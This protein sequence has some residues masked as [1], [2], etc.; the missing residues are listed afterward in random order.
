MTESLLLGSWQVR[1]ETDR[2]WLS[3]RTV[4][5]ALWA[6]ATQQ[7]GW[8]VA[9]AAAELACNAV[10]YAGG[11]DVELWLEQVPHIA[12]GLV[13]R[14]SGRGFQR[15][16]LEALGAAQGVSGEAE[17]TLL[18]FRSERHGLGIGL[19]AVHRLMSEV[20]IDSSP[21]GTTVRARKALGRT[22]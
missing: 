22:R 18:R 14:D 4:E 1:A 6:G 3:R 9:I 21:L 11:G 8:E 2:V 7:V 5:L 15:P 12:L 19:E 17:G 10:R 20:H 16:T 13:V